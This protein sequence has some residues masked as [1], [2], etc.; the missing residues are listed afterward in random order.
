MLKFKSSA[1][2]LLLRVEGLISLIK[3]ASKVNN[4]GRLFPN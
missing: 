1:P 4:L 3:R 2:I